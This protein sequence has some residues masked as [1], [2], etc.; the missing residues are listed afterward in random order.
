MLERLG[1]AVARWRYLFLAL[2]VVVALAGGIFGGGVFDR[3]E[4]TEGARGESARAHER[5]NQLSPEGET[6]VAVIGGA[7]FYTPALRDSATNVMQELRTVPGVHE[8]RD[9]YTAGGLIAADKQ[10]SLAVIEL[11]PKLN[12]DDDAALAVAD[13]VAAK[14]RT[15]DAPEV[16]VGGK[17]LAERSFAEQATKD[18][19]RG[20]A[21]AF[22]VLAVV[23]VLFGGG[24]LAGALPL[25]AALATIT[26]SLLALTA[27]ASATSISEF[28]VN[29][30]TLLGLGLAVDYSLLVIARFREERAASPDAPVPDLLATTIAGA[31]RA[32][33]VSGLAVAIA[34]AGLYVF[35]DPLLSAMA[36]GGALAVATATLAGLT[37][38]PALIAVAHHRI[39]APGTRTWVWR[40]KRRATSGLLARLAAFA[41]HR[42]APVALIVTAALLALSIPA[43]GLQV[44][45]ADARSLPKDAQERQVLE[46]VERDFTAGPVDP[47]QV[48]IAAAPTDPKVT[49]LIQRM[50]EL[51]NAKDGML[52]DDLPPS[53][54]GIEVDA[55]GPDS[56]ERA[57]Q[58]VR[59]IRDLDAPIEV[60]VGGAAAELVDAKDST[61]QRL[62]LALLV[63]G[64]PTVLLLFVL[65]RSVLIAL[66][67]V[68]LNLLT[69]GAALGVVAVALP[70]PLDITTPLLLFMFLFGLSMDYEVFLLARIKE[71]WDRSRDSDQAVLIGIS[72]SGPV[73]TAA[74]ISICV[75]FGGFALGQLA[76]VR[77]IGVGMAV[78][79]L[80]DVTV[81][82][83]L[84]LPAAM[85]LFGRWNWWPGDFWARSGRIS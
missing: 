31:G 68:V 42:P 30:V 49:A 70:G 24:L 65:T 67:A 69:L 44:A 84:L 60:L 51:P 7:D 48:L 40:R 20:E 14:L 9:A 57:Q 36:L 77:E 37:L 58:L 80:L 17:V 59:A 64:L 35:A 79:I 81:V 32:V 19:V 62:P 61:A 15:I 56:G 54:T 83:G 5:L 23:L 13:Q 25:L 76:E 74:A 55:A 16:L 33:L 72:A 73:V 52:R 85:T 4:S 41:Q 10:S 18:A 53:I 75:V 47:I 26:G 63:V 2:W 22:V 43:F 50:Q 28:A 66:K 45:D 1:R 21:I 8:V 46:A 82:R 6:V 11:D 27:L 3:T 78:A 12:D 29:V 71:E 38:V 39:P 34:L